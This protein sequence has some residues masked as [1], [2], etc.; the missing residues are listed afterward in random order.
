VQSFTID[1]ID[2]THFMPLTLAHLSAY[3]EKKLSEER[4]RET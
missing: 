4:K 1:L 2:K 3:L